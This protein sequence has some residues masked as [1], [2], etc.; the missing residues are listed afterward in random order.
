VLAQQ[1]GHQAFVLGVEVGDEHKGHPAV[2]RHRLE[3]LLEGV[4]PPAEATMPTTAWTG[5]VIGSAVCGDA[6]A[7]R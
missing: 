4:Q 1:R 6:A 5:C 2:R 3:K 7:S